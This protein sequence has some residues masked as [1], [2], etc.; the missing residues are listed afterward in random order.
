MYD[1]ILLPTDASPVAD[2]AAAHAL[3]L[4]RAYDATLHV[5]HVVDMT[6]VNW[7][8]LS[9][10]Y[11]AMREGEGRR[12][13]GRIARLADE[14]GVDSRR[15]QRRGVPATEILAYADEDVDLITLGTHGWT[16]VDRFLLG[17]VAARVARRA[18]CSVVTV[19]REETDLSTATVESL[20]YDRVL[21][22]TDG[23]EGAEPA[24]TQALDLADR[25]GAELH[26]LYVVSEGAL[27][28]RLQGKRASKDARALLEER[29]EA[30]LRAVR[31]RADGRDVPVVE[32]VETGVPHRAIRTYATERD[33]DLIAMGT[34][35]RS[36]LERVLLG[37]VAERTVRGAGRPVL[38]AR[39]A[40]DRA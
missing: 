2:R 15:V 30:A 28:T 17:S 29:G 27:G 33:V 14:L 22:A 16:G 31:E 35:G 4:A 40:E 10:G 38:T 25:F 7:T 20:A 12:A 24:V 9:E 26:A 37:S 13:T 6:V 36:G 34:R 32:S 19:R 8:T 3:A 11:Q 5:L 18:P 39:A 23:S 1:S 21:L